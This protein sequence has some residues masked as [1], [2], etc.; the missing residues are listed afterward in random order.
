MYK[1]KNKTHLEKS[2]PIAR[3]IKRKLILI[4]TALMLGLSNGMYEEDK[5]MYGNQHHT[6][7][8]QKKK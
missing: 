8:E 7:Q 6:E 2:R 4:I 3:W 1:Q 5:T